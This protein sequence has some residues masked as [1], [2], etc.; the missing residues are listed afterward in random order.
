M[1]SLLCESDSLSTDYAVFD[2]T[3]DSKFVKKRIK[4]VKPKL[5]TLNYSVAIKRARVLLPTWYDR[6]RRRLLDALP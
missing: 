3:R 2:V 1:S 4:G 6:F 5:H